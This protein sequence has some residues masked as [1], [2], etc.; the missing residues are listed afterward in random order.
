MT[1]STT[2]S[3][4]KRL[5]ALIPLLATALIGVGQS[6]AVSAPSRSDSNTEPVYFIHGIQKSGGTN[7]YGNWGNA[8]GNTIAAFKGSLGWKGSITTIGY[9]SGDTNC[10]R[11]IYPT[12]TINTGIHTL[13]KALANDIYNYH[14]KYGRSI[15]VVAHS[16]GGLIIR[17][18]LASVQRKE[19]GFPPYLY[20]EDVVTMSTPHQGS[21]LGTFISSTQAT[22]LSTGS[23]YL[24]KLPHNPQSAQGTDWTLMGSTGDYVVRPWSAEGMLGAGHLVRYQ[25]GSVGHLNINALVSGSYVGTYWNWT[26]GGWARDFTPI[27]PPA[28]VARN[29]LYYW[30]KW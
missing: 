24:S 20:V 17:D 25:M 23:E 4:G 14:S 18:A 21:A 19:A 6:A 15:D 5:L 16:M 29:A 3:R 26:G 28:T 8:D 13:A 7:C 27:A 10:T 22:Q 30:S 9:Y 12:G 2:L 11:N 1:K